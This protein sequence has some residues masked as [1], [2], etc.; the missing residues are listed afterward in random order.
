MP[1]YARNV[2]F[3]GQPVSRKPKETHLYLD[4]GGI[5]INFNLKFYP[6]TVA[7]QK[8]KTVFSTLLD[9]YFQ[10][11]GMQVQTNVLDPRQLREARDNPHLHPNLLVRVS[12][13][14]VYFNDLAPVVKDEIIERS[15]LLL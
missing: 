13:Y 15:T 3:S 10:R 7:G 6:H 5:Q 8:G 12:G 1:A 4:R 2:L 14:T 11:G 9:T